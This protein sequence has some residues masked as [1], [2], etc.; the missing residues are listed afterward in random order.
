MTN[1]RRVYGLVFAGALA[2]LALAAC[3]APA[4]EP[5]S[6]EAL[7]V[8]LGCAKCHGDNRE[9]L[10]SGPPLDT[11]QDRWQEDSLVEYFKNPK[12]V[13]EDTPRLKYIAENYPIVMPGFPNASDED[14]RKL[15]YWIH[16]PSLVQHRVA[17]SMIDSRRSSKRQSKTFIDPDGS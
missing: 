2:A 5:G 3:G 13:M 16:V 1:T 11:L 7:Y 6:P 10:R 4:P 15:A 12:A 9:G 14:L 8:D 17:V